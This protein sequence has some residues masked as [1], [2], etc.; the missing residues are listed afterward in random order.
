MPNKRDRLIERAKSRVRAQKGRLRPGYFA[1]GSSAPPAEAPTPPRPVKPPSTPP[2]RS[3]ALSSAETPKIA[4]APPPVAESPRP[5][6][7]APRKGAREW[8]DQPRATPK[9]PAPSITGSSPRATPPAPPATPP[10]RTPV[11]P[12]VEAPPLTVV[13]PAPRRRRGAARTQGLPGVEDAEFSGR[14]DRAAAVAKLVD[15]PAYILAATPNRLSRR[16]GLINLESPRITKLV[17]NPPQL[18]NFGFDLDAGGHP[19]GRDGWL[20]ASQGEHYKTL[21]VWDD[22]TLVFAATAGEEFLCWRRHRA[23]PG[24]VMNESALVESA[25]LFCELA[26]R[27]HA[28][29]EL[30]HHEIEYRLVLRELMPEGI[31]ISMVAAPGAPAT[32]MDDPDSEVVHA[33]PTA[34]V[35]FDAGHPLGANPGAVAFSLV[36]QVYS[37][38]GLDKARIPFS[39]Q[40]AGGPGLITPARIKW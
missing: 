19:E 14:I 6:P 24:L 8:L 37:W 25:Y 38:F 27:L 16:R 15:E 39:E 18:R 11:P 7:K 32:L 26:R 22:G 13:S 5:V 31:P 29:L 17:A 23:E 40:P 4:A 36:V 9:K 30:A 21:R 33:A 28:R 1:G 2:A 3:D 35:R 20:Q 10:R 34:G 12:P